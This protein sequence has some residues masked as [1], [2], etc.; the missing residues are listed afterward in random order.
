MAYVGRSI[1]RRLNSATRRSLLDLLDSVV[2]APSAPARLVLLIDGV[3]GVLEGEV[4]GFNY[5][6]AVEGR[7]VVV[8]RPQ[9]VPDPVGDLQHEY[10]QH[11]IVIHYQQTQAAEPQMLTACSMGRW[12]RWRDHP[13]YSAL[14]KPMGTPFEIVIPVQWSDPNPR[15]A[16]E[17]ILVRRS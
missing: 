14:F 9:V 16:A 1:D 4:G 13:T 8:M 17:L 3:T 6:D 2:H 10:R 5:V 15:V 12:A 11:P 7:A